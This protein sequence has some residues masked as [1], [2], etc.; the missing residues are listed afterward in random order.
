MNTTEFSY[1]DERFA[2]LQLLRYR[3]DG[4]EQLSL[5][6]K[7]LVYCLSQ[8]ALYGRDILWDQNGKFNLKIRKSLE[9]IYTHYEGSKNDRDFAELTVYLKRIWFSNGIHHHYGCD[10]FPALFHEEFL[11]E[12][13]MKLSPDLL[14]LEENQTAEDLYNEIAPVIFNPAIMPKRVNQADGDDLLL[15]SACN[16]YAEGIT[17]KEAE[18]FYRNLK[19]QNQDEHPVMYGL[20][21]Q[22]VRKNNKITEE[23]WKIDG[24]YG[25][26]IEKI[27]FWLEQ[28]ADVCEN[29]SQ[30]AVIQK[31]IEFYRTGDLRTFD[32]YS[33]LWIKEQ[34]GLIDF[35]N[36]F[37]ETYGDPLGM[38]ASW[39][40]YVNL[41]DLAAT[42]RTRKLSQNAQWFE[43]NSPVDNRFKKDSCQG[44]SAK[45]IVA[46]ILGG[47]LYPAS[48]I[49]INLPNS[50]WI[51]AEHGSKSVTIG[52]LT[53][54][55]N[56]AARGNGFKE[57]FIINKETLE[58]VEKYGDICD[59][60]HTD[61]HECLGH[62]SGKLMP[63]VDPDSLK[64][65]GATIEEARADLFGLYY[66]AD[67]KLTELGLTPDKEAYKAQY[68]TYL[69]N[70]LLTQLVRIN[71]GKDIEEAHMRNRA[72]IAQWVLEKGEKEQSVELVCHNR[73]TYVQINDYA[74]LRHLF[75]ELLAEI[76]RIKSEG[77]L[78]AARK[79][80]EHYGIKVDPSLHQ[81]I[82]T[83]YKQ[84]NLAPYKGFINPKYTP[85]VDENNQIIDIRIT[86]GEAY[87]SQMLRYS[88]DYSTL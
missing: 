60:L 31:L 84:L 20:N 69:M 22:L 58:L 32:E 1:C 53:H 77:D 44:V 9:A 71:P 24:M 86:Y 51:R 43:D 50:N 82:L 52:N 26:A 79:L 30:K 2:D 37:I 57:E 21:S 56:Q 27:V 61:L 63:G 18:D 67:N 7:K 45:V 74:K 35:T 10:K 14:P 5:K 83:R 3:V 40:G 4:F 16:Y 38:K 39:E 25:K 41:K 66:L 6:Q 73:K 17:Q 46:A 78:D 33:I 42:E 75:G 47:D 28:A 65:Y 11:K 80:V 15:T 36:G 70:G 12:E 62:G 85:V 87:D 54:A 72:L 68:Y 64:A 55:Y 88:R 29:E 49:G 19:N 8:A 81:E 59:D 76:Q 34:E 13:L 23:V 48:A